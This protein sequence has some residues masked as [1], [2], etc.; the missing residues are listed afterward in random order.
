MGRGSL[1]KEGDLGWKYFEEKGGLSKNQ[2]RKEMVGERGN[3]IRRQ[4]FREGEGVIHHVSVG[5]ISLERGKGKKGFVKR[6][7]SNRVEKA[8]L[9]KFELF[10][11]QQIYY[12]R[13][14]S[15][16]VNLYLKIKNN[17]KYLNVFDIISLIVIF[18]SLSFSCYRISIL[19]FFILILHHQF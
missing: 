18:F 7:R 12:Y 15:L 9:G 11:M 13:L 4:N 6:R 17:Q 3:Y 14:G 16:R 8:R 5:W 10:S 1:R 2:H 19:N